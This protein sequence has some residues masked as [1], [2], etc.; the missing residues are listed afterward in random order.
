LQ[1]RLHLRESAIQNINSQINYIQGNMND[2]WREI[3]KLRKELDTLRAQYA[4]SIVFAYKNRSSY[5]FLNFIFS[6]SSFNDA[7]KRVAYLKS[8]RAYREERAAN[9]LRTQQLLQGKIEGLRL[10]RAEKDEALKKQSKEMG[11]L[12]DE[13]KE[14]DAVVAKLKTQEKDLKKQMSAKQ[15]QDQRVA[16]SIAVLIRRATTEARKKAPAEKEN[17]PRNNTTTNTNPTTTKPVTSNQPYT[18]FDSKTDLLISGSFEKNKAH[19]P[20]PVGS[21]FVSMV[22]GPHEY[23]KGIIHNNLGITIDVSPGA[24]VKAV[25]EGEVQGVFTVGDVNAVMIRHGKYF[26]TYSN[27]AAVNVV[28]DEKVTTGQVLGRVADVGQLEFMLTDDK[29]HYLDPQKWLLRR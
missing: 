28:K 22:F 29:D 11:V 6:A 23:M 27:L 18:A 2:S 12:E 10:T 17:T 7:M 1:R 3:L 9:I 14:K 15:K 25:F 8:Y 4:Q 21:G 19:L 16:G 24:V 13:K 5:D 20:W 26:T